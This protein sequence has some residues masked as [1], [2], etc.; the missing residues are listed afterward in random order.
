MTSSLP[1]PA[2]MNP[3]FRSH[4]HTRFSVAALLYRRH[5]GD[6]SLIVSKCS[7][8]PLHHY[9]SFR[10]TSSSLRSPLPPPSLSDHQAGRRDWHLVQNYSK[11]QVGLLAVCSESAMAPCLYCHSLPYLYCGV[12]LPSGRAYRA[13]VRTSQATLALIVIEI[14][15]ERL[16]VPPTRVGVYVKKD[17][18]AFHRHSLSPPSGHD[19]LVGWMLQREL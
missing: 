13:T 2:E 3:T 16:T 11:T 6:T 14:P 9:F 19:E 8:T 1:P 12:I 7:F 15:Q 17:P 4:S 5:S 18:S 10:C